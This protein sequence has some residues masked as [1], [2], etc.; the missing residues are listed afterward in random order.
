MRD[1]PDRARGRLVRTAR[2]DHASGRLSGKAVLVSGAAR[3]MGAAQVELFAREGA[4]VVAGD[5]LAEE[6]ADRAEALRAEGHDVRSIALDVRKPSD[7]DA[8]VKAV[9]D[10]CGALH[11]LINNAGISAFAGAES[12]G[13]DE[14]ERVLAVNQRGVFYGMR[15]AIPALKRAGGGAIVNI[16]SVFGSGAVPGYFAYQASKAAVL[17]MSRAAAIEYAG[18]G[19]RV[20]AVSPGLVMTDM[21]RAEPPEAVQANLEL[22]PLG[23]AGT[24][25]EIAYGALYLASDEAAFVTGANLVIDGGYLAQ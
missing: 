17:Q 19:I 4:R 15:S 24:A 2:A 1:A 14:W 10:G 23:R 8:A 12:A 5:V 3:G 7:W 6:A 13:D 16:A 21:T 11:V 9:E 20:N 18:A 22:T 25:D